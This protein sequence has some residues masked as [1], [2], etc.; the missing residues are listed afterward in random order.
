MKRI[1]AAAAAL[2]LSAIFL[3]TYISAF[4]ANDYDYGGGGGYSYD[5]GGSSWDDDD[6]RGSGYSYSYGSDDYYSGGSNMTWEETL[7]TIAVVAAALILGGIWASKPLKSGKKQQPAPKSK[8]VTVPNRNVDVRSAVQRF[9]PSFSSD[10][11]LSFA[12]DTF[13]AVQ[14][15]WCAKDLGPVRG[16]MHNNLYNTTSRQVQAKIDQH[17]TYHYENYTF[18]NVYL[19][20]YVR[21]SEYEYITVYLNT[22]YIDYQTDDNTGEIIRGDKTTMWKM[23]YLMKFMRSV[24]RQT[25]RPK[26]C[27]NCGAPLDI[28][29][30]GKCEYCGSTVTASSFDWLLSDFTTVRADTKDDGIRV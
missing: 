27:P 11:M 19:T 1:S 26:F 30:S 12:K 3:C 23:R 21:D 10:R 5:Y 24:N 25:D 17:V 6:D 28:A 9:D 20:S 29:S 13:I 7:I 22:E 8:Q 2:L 15:A 14:N 18:K 4:D 16:L